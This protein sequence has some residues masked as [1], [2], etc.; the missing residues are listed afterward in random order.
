MNEILKAWL[1]GHGID[2]AETEECFQKLEVVLLALNPEV[3][4]VFAALLAQA[5]TVAVKDIE[6]SES[7]SEGMSEETF[8]FTA[9]KIFNIVSSALTDTVRATT[10]MQ[11]ETIVRL[12]DGSTGTIHRIRGTHP[13]RVA[14]LYTLDG[15]WALVG[16]DRQKNLPAIKD[17]CLKPTNI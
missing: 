3:A 4:P 9:R 11:A 13:N 12:T 5:A 15:K 10:A 16:L 1:E 2:A 14:E 8:V 6:D 7:I 17:E